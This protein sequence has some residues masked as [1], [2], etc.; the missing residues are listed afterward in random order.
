MTVQVWLVH[1]DVEV[2]EATDVNLG[3]GEKVF[4]LEDRVIAIGPKHGLTHTTFSFN[5]LSSRSFGGVDCG[6]RAILLQT[7]PVA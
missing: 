1:V 7:F 5:Q 3:L 2:E 4:F 6:T